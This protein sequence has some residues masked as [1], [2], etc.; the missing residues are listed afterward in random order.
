[1]TPSHTLPPLVQQLCGLDAR[2][3][4]RSDEELEP[5]L[6]CCLHRC[7]SPVCSLLSLLP[8]LPD[9][10]P[11]DRLPGQPPYLLQQGDHALAPHGGVVDALHPEHVQNLIDGRRRVDLIRSLQPRDSG[12]IRDSETARGRCRAVLNRHRGQTCGCKGLGPGVDWEFGMSRCK[13]LRVGWINHKIP[14][15]STG[16][17]IQHP[18]IKRNGKECE[19]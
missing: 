17:S 11:R 4:E 5:R 18:V 13:R 3:R 10:A 14:L 2:G 7:P 6:V 8:C 12:G 19:R 9:P 16:K 15:F 1:M